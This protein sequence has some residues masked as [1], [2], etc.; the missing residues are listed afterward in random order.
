MATVDYTDDRLTWDKGFRDALLSKLGSVGVAI[1][2]ATHSAQD[3]EVQEYL[4]C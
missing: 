1:E 3:I 4:L 2:A